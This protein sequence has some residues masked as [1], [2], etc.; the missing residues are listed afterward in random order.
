MTELDYTPEICRKPYHKMEGL[1]EHIALNKVLVCLCCS[2]QE[3]FLEELSLQH[4]AHAAKRSTT[5]NSLASWC[6]CKGEDCPE[7]KGYRALL[8][9]SFLSCHRLR[10]FSSFKTKLVFSRKL[11]DSYYAVFTSSWGLSLRSAPYK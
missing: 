6:L 2:Q 1:V 5:G 10:K 9:F 4:R 7:S 8:D 3:L 11:Q